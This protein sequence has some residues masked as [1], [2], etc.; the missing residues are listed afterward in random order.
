MKCTASRLH[1]HQRIVGSERAIMPRVVAVQKPAA[2]Q[3]SEEC[4]IVHL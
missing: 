3:D 4:L 2:L 1:P